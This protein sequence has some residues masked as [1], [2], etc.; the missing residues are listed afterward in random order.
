MITTPIQQS[1]DEEFR[2]I[3]SDGTQ[4]ELFKANTIKIKKIIDKHDIEC[5]SIIAF[6]DV[7]NKTTGS[8]EIFGIHLY[9]SAAPS[10]KPRRLVAALPPPAAV[11]DSAIYFKVLDK[12]PDPD[13]DLD[14]QELY[15]SQDGTLVEIWDASQQRIQ[16]HFHFSAPGIGEESIHV[17]GHFNILNT[18]SHPI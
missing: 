10:L 18:G 17:M 12:I 1:S 16:G 14:T 7:T 2:A 13:K 9:I 3:V 5:W 4:M 15:Q 11:T 8:P 6:Q